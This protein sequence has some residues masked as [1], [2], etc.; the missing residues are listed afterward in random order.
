MTIAEIEYGMEADR[1]GEKRKEAMRSYVGDRFSIVYP[2]YRTTQ[3]WAAVVASCEAKGAPIGFGY[4]W[5]AATA[6]RLCAPLVSHNARDYAC[7]DGLTV[8]TVATA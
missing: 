6:L 5:I 2:D 1:W 8:F 7:V 3:I 4:A